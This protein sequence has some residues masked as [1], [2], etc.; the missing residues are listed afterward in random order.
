MTNRLEVARTWRAK[1]REQIRE[2]NRQYKKNWRSKNGYSAEY[3]SIKRYPEKTGAR[4]AVYI[5]LRKGELIKRPCEI[6]GDRRSQ[7]HHD[8][9]SKPLEVKWLCAA[10]HADH[11]KRRYELKLPE[12]RGDIP[13]KLLSYK[14]EIVYEF[15]RPYTVNLRPQQLTDLQNLATH[16]VKVAEHIRRAIDFYLA[17]PINQRTAASE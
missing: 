2:Y 9:Y 10:H 3:A 14:E 8:D 15:N 6:C 5:A 13:V 17:M 11:E 16:H 12:M 4:K 7:A 1:H